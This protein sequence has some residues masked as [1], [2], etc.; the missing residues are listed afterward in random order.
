[1]SFNSERKTKL[2]KGSGMQEMVQVGQYFPTTSA[3]KSSML[4]FRK[5]GSEYS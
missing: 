5:S 1:M 4:Q 3:W 2:I